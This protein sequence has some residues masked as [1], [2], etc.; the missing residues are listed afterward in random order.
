MAAVM[1]NHAPWG[2]AHYLSPVWPYIARLGLTDI[3]ALL[4]NWGGV[5]DCLF[6]FI[7]AWFLCNERQSVRKNVSRAWHLEKQ[8]WFWSILLFIGCMVIW[9]LEGN[10]PGM[11]KVGLL[12]F[13]SVFPFA[14]NLWWYP[15]SYILFLLICPLLTRGLKALSQWQHASLCVGSL[16]LF[17]L[18]PS[19][20][21]P[22]D[23][24]YSL[25]CFLYL[26]VL[27]SFL[28]WYLPEVCHN[29]NIAKKLILFGLV[30]GIGTQ[31]I[32]QCAFPNNGYLWYLWMN[33]PRCLPSLCIAFG[34]I[35]LAVERKPR[36]SRVVNY[37]A[38]STLAVYLVCT[39]TFADLILKPLAKL[40]PVG[41][42][43]I[44]I[45]IGMSIVT[46]AAAIVVDAI[47]RWIFSCSV[48]RN[49]P[50][51]NAWIIDHLLSIRAWAFRNGKRFI[52][53]NEE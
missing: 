52:A 6:F 31:L 2:E 43:S 29:R 14:A 7:S 51:Q 38:G 32:I 19:R 30:F 25:V 50:A 22:L 45:V 16:L 4:S 48:D 12:A 3:V 8:L 42:V 18:V 46:Y 21:F 41:I 49:V 10:Q 40:T 15:T 17:G 11:K 24:G 39:H 44:L 53:C 47:R 28:R 34:V 33:C 23:M 13:K 36:Y 5:G 27:V 37:I 1:L 9:H 35:I 26:Y 20:L